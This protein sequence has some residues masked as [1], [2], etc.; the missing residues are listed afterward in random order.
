MRFVNSLRRTGREGR[1]TSVAN[2]SS[3]TAV[4]GPIVARLIDAPELP[5]IKS[6]ANRL[7]D[8]VVA[9]D[10]AAACLAQ[11]ELLGITP[12]SIT[13]GENEVATS[14]GRR[15][16][17]VSNAAQSVSEGV[18]KYL[19]PMSGD[20][21]GLTGNSQG[22]ATMASGF[23]GGYKRGGLPGSF[24]L[25]SP[26]G[27]CLYG[28]AGV[29]GDELGVVAYEE[30][31]ELLDRFGYRDIDNLRGWGE[32]GYTTSASS[33]PDPWEHFIN[34]GYEQSMDVLLDPTA[35]EAVLLGH[36]G[37]GPNAQF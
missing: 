19:D 17:I 23:V 28:L 24:S 10:V 12:D 11:G 15:V 26:R 9:G 30:I 14:V 34:S 6:V 1:P 13:P 4:G 22:R 33:F 16:L 29:P 2:D 36:L 37:Y 8:A 35:P 32:K 21:W 20:A 18:R 3:A 31:G 7:Q 25:V 5:E 27:D